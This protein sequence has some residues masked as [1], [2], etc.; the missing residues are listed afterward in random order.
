MRTAQSLALTGC[1]G[2]AGIRGLWRAEGAIFWHAAVFSGQATA[3]V[4]RLAWRQVGLLGPDARL[5]PLLDQRLQLGALG[6]ELLALNGPDRFKSSGAKLAQVPD[7]LHI[8]LRAKTEN[9]IISRLT[10]T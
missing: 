10:R 6:A 1:Q 9:I 5:Y 4:S 7:S 2:H 3:V 8:I